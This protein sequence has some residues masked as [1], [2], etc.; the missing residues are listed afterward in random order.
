MGEK[1]K[2][3]T[4]W[5]RERLY[6]LSSLLTS[7]HIYLS[8]KTYLQLSQWIKKK[9]SRYGIV[10]SIGYNNLS[11]VSDLKTF[12]HPVISVLCFHHVSYWFGTMYYLTD[13]LKISQMFVELIY[14]LFIFVAILL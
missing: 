14:C 3:F 1:Y 12:S 11:Y 6:M 13:H 4:S 8:T 7:V 9:N 5:E 10:S 2:G